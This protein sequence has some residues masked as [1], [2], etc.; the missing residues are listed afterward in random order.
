MKMHKHP[1]H[2]KTAFLCYQNSIVTAD[3]SSQNGSF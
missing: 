2:A 3:V 1:V